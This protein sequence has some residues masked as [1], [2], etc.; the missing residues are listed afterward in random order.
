MSHLPFVLPPGARWGWAEAKRL[1]NGGLPV[2][3][4][5]PLEHAWRYWARRFAELDVDPASAD[6]VL[7]LRLARE[8]P[9]GDVQKELARLGYER[10][11]LTRLSDAKVMIDEVGCLLS[12]ADLERAAAAPD[13]PQRSLTTLLKAFRAAAV[14]SPRGLRTRE[15]AGGIV[16][17][18]ELCDLVTRIAITLGNAAAT[19]L[20]LDELLALY[21]QEGAFCIPPSWTSFQAGPLIQTGRGCR[22]AAVTV[23]D[24]VRVSRHGF[25][26]AYDGAAAIQRGW[27]ERAHRLNSSVWNLLT[28]GGLD[29][30]VLPPAAHRKVRELDELALFVDHAFKHDRLLRARYGKHGAEFLAQELPRSLFVGL[31][32]NELA[33]SLLAPSA[34]KLLTDVMDRFDA[35]L[36]AHPT[37]RTRIAG[38]D[39]FFLIGDDATASARLCLTEQC[40]WL[41]ACSRPR[42]L[43]SWANR[44]HPAAQLPPLS[45]FMTYLRYHCGEVI[46]ISHLLWTA[47]RLAEIRAQW[48]G[49]A[50]DWGNALERACSHLPTDFRID[51]DAEILDFMPVDAK[52]H[53]WQHI[54]LLTSLRSQPGKPD[55]LFGVPIPDLARHAAPAAKVVASAHRVIIRLLDLVE[56]HRLLLPLS[57]ALEFTPLRV[58]AGMGMTEKRIETL[59]KTHS[60]E[61]LRLVY[62]AAAERAG[63]PPEFRRLRRVS[64]WPWRD[65]YEE[66]EYLGNGLGDE[67]L[68]TD[69]SG[70]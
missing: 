28:L 52:V 43:L 34:R 31:A 37:R 56:K 59:A 35:L 11:H 19:G 41:L 14:H 23:S 63:L 7:A 50:K 67:P 8:C 2:G 13:G 62:A 29:V 10:R 5:T 65:G 17:A 36:A 39:R 26:L 3:G 51:L 47:A 53:G 24:R 30:L 4:K 58:F 16:A 66:H 25:N 49:R 9:D 15:V 33:A 45:P 18:R 32:A 12:D 55:W 48:T 57:V 70:A 6:P 68:V 54:G 61:R 40:R 46:F 20:P 44:A 42:S 1:A 38:E 69:P 60:F 64:E 22:R 27:G 21:L